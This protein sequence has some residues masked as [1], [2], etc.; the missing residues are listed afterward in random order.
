[1]E[2]GCGARLKPIDSRRIAT[3]Y[4]W[5]GSQPSIV[6]LLDRK[7]GGVAASFELDPSFVFHN[8]NAFDEG[9]R[10]VMDVCAHRDSSIVSASVFPGFSSS[11]SASLW[12]SA[13]IFTWR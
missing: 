12:S 13:L 11:S 5:D 4:I 3:N 10:V 6:H 7:R 9:D 2:R 8:I 1:M